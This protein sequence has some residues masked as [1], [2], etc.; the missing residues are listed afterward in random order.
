MCDLEADRQR[1]EAVLVDALDRVVAERRAARMAFL[2]DVPARTEL[3][4]QDTRPAPVRREAMPPDP[5][6]RG[7]RAIG[8][9][10][11]EAEN[12]PDAG[13]GAALLPTCDS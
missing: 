9:G 5:G 6:Q 4:A 7:N 12:R 10:I 13:H 11:T 3:L 8:V 2:D 1:P